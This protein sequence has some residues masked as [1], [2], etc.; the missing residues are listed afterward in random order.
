MTGEELRK[1]L[2][3]VLPLDS[4][5]HLAK[6]YGVVERE[7]ELD[8]VQLVIALVLAGGT[9]EGGRQ[10]DALRRYLQSGAPAV[11]R[12]AFYAW[13][14]APLERLLTE[15]LRRAIAAGQAQPKLLPGILEGVGDWRIFDSTT[16]KLSNELADVYPG[17]GDYA[18][19]KVHK[20]FSVGTGNLVGY[21]LSPARDHDSPFL[22]V[23]ESR[24]GTGLL[25]DLGYASV[26][27]LA[28]CEAHDVRFVLRLKDNWK[29]KVDRLVRGTITR[30]VLAG[31]DFDVLLDNDVLHLDGRA[32][33]AEVTIGRSGQSLHCRMIGIH[34]P[35]GYCFFLTNLPRKTHGPHQVGDIYRLR[36]EIEIDNKVDKAGARLDEIAARKD[37]SVRILLLASL[38][39]TT[40]AR[41]IV[42]SEK[43]SI[44]RGR[45]DAEHAQRPPLHP[46]LLMR[47]LA[48]A[49]TTVTQLLEDDGGRLLEWNTLMSRLRQLGHDPNWRKRPSVLDAIQGL[50]APPGRKRSAKA[51]SA[52]AN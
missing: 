52:E 41:T 45:T 16:I 44:R 42:Q 47:A 35:K 9:H 29:P 26:T 37:V 4:I 12:G 1:H 49:H 27:R 32:I 34:T 48:I 5:R 30:D 7:R 23:D 31:E 28:E 6:E 8:I 51:R 40:V 36:W 3:E 50:T 46:I 15:L 25:I 33:D 13:F 43:L 21:Q 2:K 14:T 19:I 11:V 22:V 18:A 17:T 24:R 20:E 10:Y 39:N 38:L